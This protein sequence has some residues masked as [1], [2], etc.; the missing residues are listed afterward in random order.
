MLSSEWLLTLI[1]AILSSKE[2]LNQLI[3]TEV[4]GDTKHYSRVAL[5][6]Y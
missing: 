5:H 6:W 3:G 2:G 1:K 4:I